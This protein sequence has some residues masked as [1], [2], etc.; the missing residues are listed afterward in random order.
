MKKYCPKI[1]KSKFVAVLVMLSQFT[2]I[3]PAQSYLSE[4]NYDQQKL[5]RYLDRASREHNAQDWERIA[6]E[7][8]FAAMSEW[9]SANTYLKET[10]YDKYI[11]KRSKTEAEITSYINTEFAFWYT[12]KKLTESSKLKKSELEQ[13]LKDKSAE[14]KDFYKD[15]GASFDEAEESRKTWENYAA[16]IIDSYL[17]DLETANG[18]LFPEIKSDLEKNNLTEEQLQ[19][20]FETVSENYTQTAT[21][22]YQNVYEAEKNQLMAV[23]LYDT[24]STKKLSATQAAEAIAR[25][26]AQE[27]KT[28]TDAEINKLFND[29]ESDISNIEGEDLVIAQKNWLANFQKV[30]DESLQK[31][32]E[33]E[34]EFLVKRTEWEYEAENLFE[35][36]ESAWAEGYKVLQEKKDA[37]FKEVN[38]KFEQGLKDWNKSED[39]LNK[40][41]NDARLQMEATYEKERNTKAKLLDVQ[42][43]I[44]E[45]SRNMLNIAAQG[46]ECFAE[47]FGKYN[48]RYSYWKTEDA[49]GNSDDNIKA[50]IDELYQTIETFKNQPG[51][52]LNLSNEQIQN[53]ITLITELVACCQNQAVKSELQ[54]LIS[55]DSWIN[56][57]PTYKAKANDAI[58]QLYKITGC[59]YNET[60]DGEVTFLNELEIQLLKSKVTLEYW[61]EEF[62]VALAVKEYAQSH[63]SQ[64][65]TD[66][67]TLN[68]LNA[69]IAEYDAALSTY[70]STVAELTDYLTAVE[71]KQSGENG[72]DTTYAAMLTE[73]TALDNLNTKYAELLVVFKGAG[74]ESLLQKLASLLKEY[75]ELKEYDNTAD[76]NA[77]YDALVQYNTELLK[78]NLFN[79]KNDLQNGKKLSAGDSS[80]SSEY[81]SIQELTDYHNQINKFVTNGIDLSNATQITEL[82]DKLDS[83]KYYTYQEVSYILSYID[84]YDANKDKYNDN[85]KNA[86]KA[87]ILQE[88]KLIDQYWQNQIDYRNAALT[89]IETGSHNITQEE[90]NADQMTELTVRN[91]LSA[92]IDGTTKWKNEFGADFKDF[93]ELFTTINTLL[94]VTGD[95]FIS[96]VENEC[97]TNEDLRY[98]LKQYDIF[99][100]EN[101][102]NWI[103]GECQ[104]KLNQVTN[105]I[106]NKDDIEYYYSGYLADKAT[107]NHNDAV[108]QIK[109]Y[110]ASTDY[111]TLTEAQVYSYMNQLN[112]LGSNLNI[113]GQS[114]LSNYLNG[115]LEYTG[116]KY[117][118][119]NNR[120]KDTLNSEIEAE[121][122]ELNSIVQDLSD[123]STLSY[124]ISDL[125][126][127]LTLIENNSEIY[128]ENKDIF[129]EYTAYLIMSNL[130]ANDVKDAQTLA[131]AI[132]ALEPEFDNLSNQAK[133][134]ICNTIL[135]KYNYL[136]DYDEYKDTVHILNDY[137][138]VLAMQDN[139][140][141]HLVFEQ[142]PEDSVNYKIAQANTF[143][144]DYI[145]YKNALAAVST[146]EEDYD[147]IIAEINEEFENNLS[148]LA[149]DNNWVAK[150]EQDAQ[151]LLKDWYSLYL[152]DEKTLFIYL[153]SDMGYA[154]LDEVQDK[155]T[156]QNYKDYLTQFEKL[157]NLAY[158]Y[159]DLLDGD[160]TTWVNNLSEPL[161]DAEKLML[162]EAINGTAPIT[163]YYSYENL[164]AQILS[165]YGAGIYVQNNTALLNEA[166]NQIIAEKYDE[167]YSE[168]TDMQYRSAMLNTALDAIVNNNVT[169]V[170]ELKNNDITK[171]DFL[172]EESNNAITKWVTNNNPV[173]TLLA[174]KALENEKHI[175]WVYDNSGIPDLNIDAVQGTPETYTTL[176]N[177]AYAKL[178]AT[179]DTSGV[180]S[181]MLAVNNSLAES[182]NSKEQTQAKLDTLTGQI[183]V[184]KA[185]YETAVTNW[186][187]SVEA[188][189]TATEAY[190]TKV[191]AADAD[192]ATLKNKEKSK[193]IAQEKYD[194]AT[195]IYL[196]EMGEIDNASYIS[197][198]EKLVDISYS[199]QQAQVT[200]DVLQELLG[201]PYEQNAEYSAAME[202]Y[203]AAVKDHYAV[204][205]IKQETDAAIAAQEDNVR[206]ADQKVQEVSTAV[207]YS[208]VN[209]TSVSPNMK[210]VCI[211]KD[212]NGN[213]SFSLAGN[214]KTCD[215]QLMLEY[216][217]KNVVPEKTV[218]GSRNI[219][220]A[221]YDTREWIDKIN[222][223]RTYS[224]ELMLASVWVKYKN[225]I[226]SLEEFSYS[227]LPQNKI[228]GID[229][230]GLANTY[231][232]QI[233]E[234]A[235]NSIMSRSGGEEDLARYL[236]YVQDTSGQGGAN[237]KYGTTSFFTEELLPAYQIRLLN[238]L[239]TYCESEYKSKIAES[240]ALFAEAAVW[241]AAAA[242]CGWPACLIP[243]AVAAGFSIAGGTAAYK[244]SVIKNELIDY[245]KGKINGL[246][247]NI[248]NSVASEQGKLNDVTKAKNE[249]STEWSSLN[250]MLNGSDSETSSAPTVALIKDAMSERIKS[251]LN[252]TTYAA[253]IEHLYTKKAFESSGAENCASVGEAINTIN[254]WYEA[255][256][257]SSE[258]NLARVVSKL[259]SAQNENT[260]TFADK[261]QANANLTEEQKQKLH[262]LAVAASNEELS[263]EER[264][265]AKSD[266]DALSEQYLAA[267]NTYKKALYNL[268]EKTWGTKTW[269]SDVYYKDQTQLSK[270]LYRT[271]AINLS[272]PAE[273]YSRSALQSY[274]S[275]VLASFDQAVAAQMQLF[276]VEQDKERSQLQTKRN[277][278]ESQM[279]LISSLAEVEWAKAG[280]SLVSG[281]NEWRKSFTKEYTQK[282]LDW[283]KNYSKF[284]QKK[285]E[286]VNEQYLYAVN[287]GNAEVL[288]NSGLDVESAIASSLAELN[289]DAIELDVIDPEEYTNSLIAAT[290]LGKMM[291]NVESLQNRGKDAAVTKKHGSKMNTSSIQTIMNA[292]LVM[293]QMEEAIENAAAKLAGEQAA[294]LI[295]K[296]IEAS[297]ER[298]DQENK[299]MRDWEI[300]LVQSNSYTVNDK[301]IERD[302]VIDSTIAGGVYEHQTV[303]FYQDFT[304]Q[305]P[306]LTVSLSK[307]MLEGL[308]NST[309]MMLVSQANEEIE[310]WNTSIFGQTEKDEDGNVVQKQWTI[311]RVAA[312]SLHNGSAE[313][314]EKNYQANVNAEEKKE[315]DALLKKGYAYLTK[316]EKER[317]DE[318]S[319]KLVTVRDGELGEWIGYAP[320]FKDGRDSN[321]IKDSD[322]EALG[323]DLEEGREANLKFEGSGQMGAIMLDFQWNSIKESQGWGK[324]AM[325][326]YDQALWYSG[327]SWFKAP[328]LRSVVSIAFDAVSLVSGQTWFGYADDLIFA[329]CDFGGGYKSAEEVGLDLA[330]TAAT[331]VISMGFNAAGTAISTS[332]TTAMKGASTTAKAF[333][334][335]A[336]MA[337]TTY[338]SAVASN[339]VHSVN[340]DYENGGLKFDKKG[341]KNSLT[342]AGTF[343]TALGAGVT[344]GLTYGISTNLKSMG[345]RGAQIQKAYGGA[346]NL[347]ISAAQK[348]TEYGVYSAFALAQGRTFGDAFEDMGGITFNLLDLGMFADLIAT[349]DART[350]ETGASSWD[351]IANNLAG[352]GV[353]EFTIGTNGITGNFGTGGINITSS[354]YDLVKRN[355]DL[356]ALATALDPESENYDEALAAY[357]TYIFGDRQQENTAMRVNSGKDNLSIVDEK[358]LDP[359]VKGHTTK[360][361]KGGRDIQIA[362]QGSG[363]ENAIVLGHEAYRDGNIDKDT[364]ETLESL[365]GHAGIAARMNEFEFV[366]DQNI[367]A[368]IELYKSGA[369]A[370]LFLTS[371]ISYDSSEDYYKMTYG[372]QLEKDKDGWLKNHD[373]K[374]I[375]NDGTLSDEPIP[376]KTYGAAGIAT[377]LINILH[378]TSNHLQ[379]EWSESEFAFVESIMERSGYVKD[380]EGYWTSTST[381][382]RLNMN[383]IMTYYGN[384]I[385]ATVFDTYYNNKV[386]IYLS[387]L[388][389]VNLGFDANNKILPGNA[390]YRYNAL[391]QRHAA[392]TTNGKELLDK[393]FQ[394][395][396]NSDGDKSTFYRVDENNPFLDLLIK[397]IDPAFGSSDADPY[398]DIHKAACNWFTIMSYPQLMTGSILTA[399]EIK[400]YYDL[401]TTT[402]T[403]WWENGE[404]RVWMETSCQVWQPDLI[405][406]YVMNDLNQNNDVKFTFTSATKQQTLVGYKVK[407]PYQST[408]HFV[409]GSTSRKIIANSANGTGKHIEEI[410]VYAKKNDKPK[411]KK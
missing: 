232:S 219:T 95:N 44:Y 196:K 169:W 286:W 406:N 149:K 265:K 52:F 158:R 70:N 216:F 278:W 387:S 38:E 251:L 7:G 25:E 368:E 129:D 308:D 290:S 153:Q 404:D 65:E 144:Q 270:E 393:Y 245:M 224:E 233:F 141:Y 373:G 84:E 364:L 366:F 342:S 29:F 174:E 167:K 407:V 101:L 312:D 221:L 64:T 182:K 283:E 157:N 97:K 10:D 8:V 217:T 210:L 135:A 379:A 360:N 119:S 258:E 162:I 274:K 137:Y 190:N 54:E 186:K 394:T 257:V 240:I 306:T 365:L 369:L 124:T 117:A 238:K 281:Y 315:Y 241:G 43:S 104:Y 324:L 411:D 222:Q 305:K 171:A 277:E 273:S 188:L 215:E 255:Q 36:S 264:A 207:A 383:E 267:N 276:D 193:R 322:N 381:G 145:I 269:H 26:T 372:G 68:N 170:T 391:I 377:G 98:L 395:I 131:Q 346:I 259:Q 91:Y 359:G 61:N 143:I 41:L 40:Q 409:T 1:L 57:I 227:E 156:N 385:A 125:N 209:M 331:A 6:E 336:I 79:A 266:F 203:K 50:K 109:N 330:K 32:N 292:Q 3:L 34:Q 179:A 42:I 113:Y 108:T 116:I 90:L 93:E 89:Y 293:Q 76:F 35:E 140:A 311:P 378:G 49:N 55:D 62:E 239:I 327:D 33:A 178:F 332:A 87:N 45:Q 39:E 166:I 261:V 398:Y 197:P 396:T 82:K 22:E 345:E 155:L 384:T 386:D 244:A 66:T 254:Q 260:L 357:M 225:G 213:Y 296:S 194:W 132:K 344:A 410:K 107:V 151:L 175:N 271:N 27:V 204:L 202:Q 85:Q 287:M 47:S 134:D 323:L 229:C 126:S 284:L 403:P 363:A 235:Y 300:S 347:G 168:Y 247:N 374:Y 337:T 288:D 17:S 297:M 304:T 92:V 77:Y 354:V 23:L 130:Y 320:Q 205:I 4:K 200:V 69:A 356:S 21:Q 81:K 9:E 302:A 78:T 154:Y 268:A 142:A 380:E 231:R 376:G 405:A 367:M 13:L 114:A 103:A 72:V 183:A 355:N 59:V 339:A 206:A 275:M 282:T 291:N 15:T 243:A 249:L 392:Q 187:N 46:L 133:N 164:Q 350:N 340:I 279:L 51:S 226:M 5:E 362:N 310:D 53:K 242:C 343:A 172:D 237:N 159:V 329:A 139:S 146:E 375:N 208:P 294:L 399:D 220:K 75:D 230:K 325:P 214:G 122:A 397:Q 353:L 160:V 314:T 150:A 253:D 112:E 2:Y 152:A 74:T 19:K 289:V 96:S 341:F 31:W 262:K 181:E 334:K 236:I 121:N 20:I 18:T 307:T 402:T 317:F 382:K 189:K 56:Y 338:V 211:Q 361:E 408:G 99:N 295:E 148:Q 390:W 388:Y 401:F 185:A 37:W 24:Q 12:E 326:M 313:S 128:S 111:K 272:N 115:V 316:S 321:G 192:F 280:E 163:S 299:A 110:I 28:E 105:P 218:D 83:T 136:S 60:V 349:N 30:F 246:K 63:S 256:K 123:L 138:T 319:S 73:K 173:Q 177:N 58:E 48:N 176:L 303:V 106:Q 16:N 371:M 195:S 165:T 351:K 11:Q 318:L 191:T 212:S 252:K 184:Q 352:F 223:D 358:D 120:T 180:I 333:T 67:E 199:M 370:E 234:A 228:Q 86:L 335:G 248:S 161:T 263:A 100:S 298:I 400:A 127:V 389:G 250:K 80:I 328:T 94:S 102:M 285:Q 14:Y 348:I 88:L 147:D 198:E 201:K 71:E 301:T 118:F 309:I